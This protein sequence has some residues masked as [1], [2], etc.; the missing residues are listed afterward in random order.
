MVCA[1]HPVPGFCNATSVGLDRRPAD[2]LPCAPLVLFDFTLSS[3][4]H[5]R[6]IHPE[7]P[8]GEKT[9]SKSVVIASAAR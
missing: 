2:R 1:V 4:K 3:V 6:R 9:M 5:W 7:F 8:K